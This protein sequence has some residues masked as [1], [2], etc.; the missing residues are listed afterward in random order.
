[1]YIDTFEDVCTESHSRRSAIVG[2]IALLSGC[3][4]DPSTSDIQS[5][6][7]ETGTNQT[8]TNESQQST[9]QNR[10]TNETRTEQPISDPDVTLTYGESVVDGALEVVVENL[11]VETSVLLDADDPEDNGT[12]VNLPDGEALTLAPLTFTNRHETDTIYLFAPNFVLVGSELR[13]EEIRSIENPQSN[14]RIYADDVTRFD[15]FFFRWTTHGSRI[16]PGQSVNTA[17]MF[18]VPEGTTT[19]DI[20]VVYDSSTWRD[21]VDD[22]YGTTTARWMNSQ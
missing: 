14:D 3:L 17:A 19:E 13:Q 15:D 22:L 10:T 7:N 6:T 1:M 16:E 12:Q 21:S 9:D 5:R 20:A 2:G 4:S 11:T 8:K 18:E